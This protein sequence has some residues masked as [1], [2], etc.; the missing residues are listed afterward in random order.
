MSEDMPL[1]CDKLALTDL[2]AQ[3]AIIWDQVKKA[4]DTNHNG[5]WIGLKKHSI[6]DQV[7]VTKRG[8]NHGDA[9]RTI[10]NTSL[11]MMT[12]TDRPFFQM[13]QSFIDKEKPGEMKRLMIFGNPSL[14]EDIQA[15]HPIDWQQ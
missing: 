1:L 9:F 6:V 12:D 15:G 13:H 4:M 3:P 5:V 7:R 2:T 8:M 10:E 11:G 14:F